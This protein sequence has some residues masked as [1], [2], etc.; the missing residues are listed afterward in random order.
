MSQVLP[1]LVRTRNE[2]HGLRPSGRS[3]AA[4]REPEP[5]PKPAF[6]CDEALSPRSCGKP[7][8]TVHGPPLWTMTPLGRPLTL[9]I[10][11][12]VFLVRQHPLS[13]SD[14]ERREAEGDREDVARGRRVFDEPS[15]GRRPRRIAG[16]WRPG[17]DC[18]IAHDRSIPPRRRTRGPKRSAL[19]PV[20]DELY[21]RR[22]SARSASPRDR[23]AEATRQV[24]RHALDVAEARPA[25]RRR[26][27]SACP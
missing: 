18:G 8:R 25:D 2:A 26:D 9:R 27:G 10:T 22:R 3:E 21:A 4:V 24:V 13:L 20:R 7:V 23:D 16:G 15:S 11:V 19:E 6:P 1:P 17:D 12:D 14:P 5:N